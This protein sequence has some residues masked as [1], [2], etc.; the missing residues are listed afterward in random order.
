MDQG[1]QKR[2]SMLT[3]EA[4]LMRQ[5]EILAGHPRVSSFT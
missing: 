1:L 4:S 3:V 5:S 2:S